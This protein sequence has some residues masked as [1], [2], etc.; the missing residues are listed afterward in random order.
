MFSKKFSNKKIKK[1]F[2]KQVFT[3]NKN[4]QVKNN[5]PKKVFKKVSKKKF[6]KQGFKTK[7]IDSPNSL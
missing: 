4:K 5:L 6:S 2:Q 1:N 3:T 7:L